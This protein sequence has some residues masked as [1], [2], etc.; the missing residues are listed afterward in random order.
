M[1]GPALTRDT[2]MQFQ[3]VDGIVNKRPEQ[4]AIAHSQAFS[5]TDSSVLYS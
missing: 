2:G 4:A 3:D 1:I 5:V